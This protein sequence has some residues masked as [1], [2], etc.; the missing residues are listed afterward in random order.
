MR[1]DAQN[2]RIFAYFFKLKPQ[3]IG[4]QEWASPQAKTMTEIEF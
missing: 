2:I 1:K 3:D 4:L